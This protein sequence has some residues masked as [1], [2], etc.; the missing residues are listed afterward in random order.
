MFRSPPGTGSKRPSRKEPDEPLGDGPLRR[1]PGRPR[2]VRHLEPRQRV[3]VAPVERRARPRGAGNG[4]GDHES[5]RHDGD[6]DRA[7]GDVLPPGG[8]EGRTSRTEPDYG[9]VTAQV[10]R[11]RKS[12]AAVEVAATA[13]PHLF[14][15]SLLPLTGSKTRPTA[16]IAGVLSYTQNWPAAAA[17]APALPGQLEP[18]EEPDVM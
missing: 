13:A 5:G 18:P 10:P 8:P 17:G 14:A 6:E 2:A 11:T 12:P 9:A 3:G 16:L 15:V 1:G 4:A 7:K